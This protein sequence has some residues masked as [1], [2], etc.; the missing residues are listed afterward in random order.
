MH[1]SSQFTQKNTWHAKNLAEFRKAKHIRMPAFCVSSKEKKLI[2]VYV[3][4]QLITYQ[5]GVNCQG[6]GSFFHMS[7]SVRTQMERLLVTGVNK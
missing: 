3:P 1:N 2:S 5:K 4:E 7:H 6:V